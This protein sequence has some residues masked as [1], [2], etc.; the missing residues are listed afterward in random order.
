MVGSCVLHTYCME[1]LTDINLDSP[2][3]LTLPGLR[4]SRRTAIVELIEDISLYG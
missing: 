3:D 2:A 4:K 1:D